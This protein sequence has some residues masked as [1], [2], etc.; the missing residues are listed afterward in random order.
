MVSAL[1]GDGVISAKFGAFDAYT[2][3]TRAVADVLRYPTLRGS[4]ATDADARKGCRIV[5]N[6]LWQPL[7]AATA[8]MLVTPRGNS[9]VQEL[10]AHFVIRPIVYPL[11]RS[12][13]VNGLPIA[14]LCSANFSTV[15]SPGPGP[16]L[17]RDDR[18]PICPLASDSPGSFACFSRPV[19]GRWASKTSN[20]N[21]FVFMV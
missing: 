8:C 10:R 7:L 11:R 17:V 18:A 12:T 1:R 15:S 16:R 4:T 19:V 9:I 14:T 2:I 3:V 13:R 6:T 5:T 21:F 20:L